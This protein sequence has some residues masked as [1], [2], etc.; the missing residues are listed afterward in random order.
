[1]G[2]QVSTRV[3]PVHAH[4]HLH[5]MLLPTCTAHFTAEHTVGLSLAFPADRKNDPSPASLSVFPMV[6]YFHLL[7]INVH[8]VSSSHPRKLTAFLKPP[9]RAAL[10]CRIVQ[11]FHSCLHFLPFTSA[12]SFLHPDPLQP[13]SRFLHPTV[14]P[15]S[16]HLV[17]QHLIQAGLL[18]PHGC[19]GA[20]PAPRPSHSPPGL[21]SWPRLTQEASST[22]LRHDPHSPTPSTLRI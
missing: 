18:L 14:F 13:S 2:C 8:V 9:V 22:I 20:S 19:P 17:S 10:S 5:A 21:P 7:K 3:L 1:M 4:C 16:F 12:I 6:S 11:K 15:I